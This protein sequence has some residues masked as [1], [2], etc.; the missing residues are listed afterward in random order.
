MP[1]PHLVHSNSPLVPRTGYGQQVA[2]F[3]PRLNEHHEVAIS[4]FYGTA[5][6]RPSGRG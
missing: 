3:A 6:A 1:D 4:A 2:L 5:G